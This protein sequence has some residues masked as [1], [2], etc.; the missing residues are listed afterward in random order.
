MNIFK[1]I[2]LAYEC[3]KMLLAKKTAQSL[4]HDQCS[5]LGSKDVHENF[6]SVQGSVQ[7]SKRGQ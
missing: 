6:C 3:G 2:Y 7:A 4:E 1:V 5:V